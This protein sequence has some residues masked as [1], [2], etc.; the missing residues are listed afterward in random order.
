VRLAVGGRV[1]GYGAVPVAAGRL[2]STM[3]ALRLVRLALT[4]AYG[5]AFGFPTLRTFFNVTD[6]TRG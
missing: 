4:I 2:Y 3:T 5:Y 6:L 1:M